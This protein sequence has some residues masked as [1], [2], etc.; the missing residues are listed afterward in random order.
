[1]KRISSGGDGIKSSTIR[2]IRWARDGSDYVY[3][4]VDGGKSEGTY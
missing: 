3:S 1:M 2:K 4:H